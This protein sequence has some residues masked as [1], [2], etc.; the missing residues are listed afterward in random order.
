MP[1]QRKAAEYQLSDDDW[2]ELASGT[3]SDEEVDE[4]PSGDVMRLLKGQLQEPRFKT[5]NLR[6]LHG[7]Y[8][9]SLRLLL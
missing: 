3:N 9:V 7:E 8:Q 4:K 1:S 6:Q 5:A 2:D